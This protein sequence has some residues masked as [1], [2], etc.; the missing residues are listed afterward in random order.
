MMN[1]KSKRRIVREK[2]LQILYAYE[3][4][5][6]SLEPLSSEI[7]NEITDETDRAFARELI[8]KV[9]SNYD[10]LDKRI[11]GR[12]T[13]WEMNR[14]ALIDKILLRIGICEILYF[15]DIP[16]KVSINESIEIAKDFST[17]GSGKFINGILDAIL[18]EEKK[19][20]RLNKTGRGLVEESISP[21][22]Q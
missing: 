22:R 8:S 21:S 2:V 1:N 19:E 10:D 9:L 16:P 20:G 4:N 15:P 11:I 17:A 5:R 13:N 7:L 6:E 12:V 3:M 14:I 18:A